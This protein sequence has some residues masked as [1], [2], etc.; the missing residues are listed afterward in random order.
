MHSAIAEARCRDEQE[1]IIAPLPSAWAT[2]EVSA[3]KTEGKFS[4]P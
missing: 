3:K 1:R 2:G 4:C